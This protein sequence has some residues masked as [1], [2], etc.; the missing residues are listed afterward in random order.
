M[1]ERCGREK[2]EGK[3]HLV[4]AWLV[5]KKISQ[6]GHTRVETNELHQP[7]SH[8]IPQV[9]DERRE[10]LI[11]LTRERIRERERPVRPLLL[12][13]MG[14]RTVRTSRYCSDLKR[15]RLTMVLHSNWPGRLDSNCIGSKWPCWSAH[16]HRGRP[17]TEHEHWQR[18]L[19]RTT[20]PNTGDL[21]EQ[22]G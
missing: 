10:H 1:D 3:T 22:H 6:C 8:L 20:H 21:F 5:Y 9:L 4:P 16:A 12:T 11:D 15:E 17:P 14:G 19:E 18:G 7:R 2:R 13:M